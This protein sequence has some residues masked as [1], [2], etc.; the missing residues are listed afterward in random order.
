MNT[1][2]FAWAWATGQA[3]VTA[4]RQGNAD[5]PVDAAFAAFV[6][7]RAVARQDHVVEAVNPVPVVPRLLRVES[8]PGAVLE[9][10]LGKAPG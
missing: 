10:R 8:A 9:V 1:G 6:D 3:A 4:D 2:F 5:D 7:G